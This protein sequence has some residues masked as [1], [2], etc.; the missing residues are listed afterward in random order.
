MY[1]GMSVLGL[2]T[3]RG[4]SKRIP[5]KNIRPLGGRPLVAWTVQA[6]HDS[7]LVDRLVLSSE[8]REIMAIAESL[9]CDVPFRRP[10]ELATDDTSSMDV[11][12]HALDELPEV[13][14]YVLL[15]QPT[16]PF[17]TSSHTRAIIE[18]CLDVHGDMMISVS[19]SKKHPAFM[20]RIRDG[21]L[22]P[23]MQSDRHWTRQ[24]LPAVYEHNGALYLARTEHLRAVK[25]YNVAGALP[26]EMT[27]PADIDLDDRDDWD[28]AEYLIASGRAP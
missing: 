12:F 4:Q 6:A 28:Y 27:H 5:R 14:D 24:D 17:R 3:A 18:R 21:R 1:R 10:H 9:G 25:S 19:K 23:V 20:H 2:I 16:S 13:F 26:F 22:E 15:L 7:G 11:I 8:D